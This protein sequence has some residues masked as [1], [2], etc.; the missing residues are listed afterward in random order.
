M[1]ALARK[2]SEIKNKEEGLNIIYV[3]AP[4]TPEEIQFHLDRAFEV[5]FESV[6]QANPQSKNLH[7][8]K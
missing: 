4:A 6:F 5:L 8:E 3:P 7:Y 1:P 2:L